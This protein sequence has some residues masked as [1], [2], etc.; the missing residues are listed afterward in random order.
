M[1]TSYGKDYL[2]L[3]P[4]DMMADQNPEPFV[5]DGVLMLPSALAR[6]GIT[7]IE[8]DDSQFVTLMLSTGIAGLF[9]SYTSEGA[10]LF[11]AKLIQMADMVDA[12]VAKAAG[13]AIERARKAGGQ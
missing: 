6:A 9:V 5:Q 7:G 4:S 11:A 13:D 2:H 12:D 1:N 10:R 3:G 8:G